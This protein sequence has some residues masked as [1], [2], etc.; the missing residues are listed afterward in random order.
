MTGEKAET[1]MRLL[2]WIQ[3]QAGISRRKAQELIAAGEVNLNDQIES[4]PFRLI[5]PG[6]LDSASLRG[7]PLAT[8]P[9]EKR[10][11]RFHKPAGMLCSHDDPHAGNTVGRVLRAEG[12]IGY[13]WAGRLD[14]D[15]EGLLVVTNDGDLVQA[16]SHPRYEVTKTYHV[17]LRAMP[18]PGRLASVLR[19]MKSGIEEGGETLR[20][21]DGRAGGGRA[22]Q[23]QHVILTLGEGRKHEIK[24]LFGAFDLEVTRLVRVSMGSVQLGTLPRGDFERLAHQEEGTTLSAARELLEGV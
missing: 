18:N 1:G 16:Y 7:Y 2:Q 4:D 20:I 17:W 9:P 13:T 23:S 3:Q 10:V 8:A 5:A 24:R 12:F 22:K 14:R 21:L 6:C 19:K 11:Y 15:A